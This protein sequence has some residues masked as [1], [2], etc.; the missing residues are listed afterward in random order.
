MFHAL[1]NPTRRA[2]LE[3][4][5]RGETTVSDLTAQFHVSQPAISQ[6]LAALRRA[7]LVSDRHRGRHVYY[8]A[9]AAGLAPLLDWV[10][11]YQTFWG[12][13]ADRLR[14]LL[15]EMDDGPDRG[16]AQH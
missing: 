9:E 1:A 15:K 16:S 10:D 4:L 5:V 6:H 8:R 2:V 7:G 12:E 11:R 13:R 3:R 14:A